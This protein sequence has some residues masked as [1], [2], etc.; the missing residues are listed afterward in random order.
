M[1]D[2]KELLAPEYGVWQPIETAPKQGA[3]LIAGGL[4]QY[5]EHSRSEF[6]G[7]CIA[8]WYQDHWR[9]DQNEG[10]DEWNIHWPTHWMPLPELPK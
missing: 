1:S 10:H 8:Y 9:G 5:Y 6:K 7:I 2:G 3:I 4:Y